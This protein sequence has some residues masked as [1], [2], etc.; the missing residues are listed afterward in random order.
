[1]LYIPKPTDEALELYYCLIKEDIKKALDSTIILKNQISESILEEIIKSKPRDLLRLHNQFNKVNL[2]IEIKKVFNFD[3]IL[4]STIKSYEFANLLS[5]YTCTYCN[6]LYTLTIEKQKNGKITRPQFDHWFPKSKYPLLAL[7]YFNLIP[8]CP[9]CNGPTIKGKQVLDLDLHIHP[10]DQNKEDFTFT[11]ELDKNDNLK[12]KIKCKENSKMSKT[13]EVFK[14]EE[15]YN[16]HS[17]L[18]LKDLVDLR[19]RYSENY[20]NTLINETFVNA[21]ITKKDA[22]RMIF[23]IEY[24]DD[25]FHKRSFSKF[26]SD[27]I[28]ELLD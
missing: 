17:N 15:I 1:M 8:C 22:I 24:E 27:I 10:Y 3:K 16:A 9:I 5:R 11:Y 13:L 20:I 7:S 14:I 26:K 6:R 4:S 21:A 25:D 28:K 12:V 23:G 2:L 19:H 18:E